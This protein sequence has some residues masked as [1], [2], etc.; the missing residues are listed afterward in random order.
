MRNKKYIVPVTRTD[1]VHM[2]VIVSARSPLD[3]QRRVEM[4]D[5][6]ELNDKADVI[7]VDDGDVAVGDAFE[8][9]RKP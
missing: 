4:M 9:G 3:A 7:D 2:H 8:K 5:E 1:R 6:D